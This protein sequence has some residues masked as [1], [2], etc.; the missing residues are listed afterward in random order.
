MAAPSST[1]ALAL[2]MAGN[3]RDKAAAALARQD[4]HEAVCEAFK[5]EIRDDIAELKGFVGTATWKLIV[6]MAAVIGT[7]VAKGHL[8]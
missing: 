2:E 3:A 1:A 4:T 6:A 8:F 5:R 7:V